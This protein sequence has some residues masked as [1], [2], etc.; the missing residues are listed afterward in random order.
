MKHLPSA[1]MLREITVILNCGQEICGECIL[2]GDSYV[3]IRA[4][5]GYVWDIEAEEIAAI[6]VKMEVKA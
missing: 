3:R 6:G 1:A 4:G 5:E 2:S